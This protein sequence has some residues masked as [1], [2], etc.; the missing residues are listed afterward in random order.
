[1]V[2]REPPD[3]PRTPNSSDGDDFD[4]LD[5]IHLTDDERA[6]LDEFRAKRNE[7]TGNCSTGSNA[8][9]MARFG[10]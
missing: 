2:G 1:M 6:L 4:A 10:R 9:T 5:G 8:R 3:Q 7:P